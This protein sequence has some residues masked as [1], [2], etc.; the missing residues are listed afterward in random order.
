MT[1]LSV[2][3]STYNEANSIGNTLNKLITYDNID[4]I[5][6]VDDNSS[7]GTIEI[8]KNFK[9]QKIKLYVRKDTKGFS[10]AFIYGIIVS[11]GTHILRFDA[12]MYSS[13]DLFIDAYNKNNEIDCIIFS[14]YVNNGTDERSNYRKIP[15]LLINKLCQFILSKRIKDYTSCIM[16]FKRELLR[17]IQISNSQ[18]AN[19]IIKFI[20]DIIYKKKTFKE[21]GFKQKKETEFNSKSAASF[22]VFLKNGTFYFITILKCFLI[23]ILYILK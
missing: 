10:S 21:I 15:S 12:D 22:F 6:I 23:R 18:Y 8:I 4:E 17:D 9:N 19:F 20:F 7:D 13:I 2:I 3:I 1:S 14:R 16:I 11:N 5:V